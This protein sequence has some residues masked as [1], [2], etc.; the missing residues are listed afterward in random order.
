MADPTETV[1]RN[2]DVVDL[3]DDEFIKPDSPKVKYKKQNAKKAAIR[4]IEKKKYGIDHVLVEASDDWEEARIESELSR[5]LDL[6]RRD[7]EKRMLTANQMKTKRDSW[8]R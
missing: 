7:L 4:D 8:L 3:S 2:E 6:P 5:R 1:D